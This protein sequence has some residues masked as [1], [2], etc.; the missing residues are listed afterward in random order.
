MPASPAERCED[1]EE[2]RLRRLATYHRYRRAN[3]DDR[4]EKGRLRMAALRARESSAQREERLNHHREAQKKYRE[5]FREQIAHR[6]RRAAV[7]KN[8]S[9][10]KAT[11]LRPKARQY[12]S[13][14]E[15]IT[16]DEEEEEEDWRGGVTVRVGI[17]VDI[18]PHT[19]R[20]AAETREEGRR[21][22]LVCGEHLTFPG[23]VPLF[24]LR[25]F[26]PQCIK[27]LPFGCTIRPPPRITRA[28]PSQ[29]P[30][31]PSPTTPRQ[32]L[33][34]AVAKVA[35]VPA[36]IVFHEKTA[37]W[38][39]ARRMLAM[40]RAHARRWW[41]RVAE[42]KE[43]GMLAFRTIAV[44]A[45]DDEKLLVAAHF[46]A[47]PPALKMMVDICVRGLP[48]RP[49]QGY[50]YHLVV[51][52][53]EVG[54]FDNWG[55]A[56]ASLTGY[57]GSVNKGF[58]SIAECVEA[59][60]AMCPLGVHPHPVDPAYAPADA[61]SPPTAPS[62]RSTPAPSSPG[63][64]S[65]PTLVFS[66]SPPTPTFI[67]S[68]SP[69][70]FPRSPPRAPNHVQ[71]VHN[72]GGQ[73]TP[74]VRK[75]EQ[76]DGTPPERHVEGTRTAA[77]TPCERAEDRS[78]DP[79][80]VNFAI[81]GRGIVSGSSPW[82]YTR[83]HQN[84]MTRGGQ[85]AR[86]RACEGLAPAKPGRT[87]WIHGTKVAF[88]EKFKNDYLKAAELGK[89]QAGK[90]YD[91]VAHA[92][93]KIYGYRLALTDDLPEGETVASDV[94]ED[95]DINDLPVEEALARSAHFDELRGC[96]IQVRREKGYGPVASGHSGARPKTSGR[97]P[98]TPVFRSG[99]ETTGVT[100][101]HSTEDE[102]TTRATRGTSEQKGSIPVF[103]DRGEPRSNYRAQKQLNN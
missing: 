83:K 99:R 60:Q 30:F 88:M 15:L 62:A 40:A 96:Y 27:G 89:V 53:H 69:P 45:R 65:T 11:K 97:G 52:G 33:G 47:R 16:D 8:E 86:A 7:K 21:R 36:E 2:R 9:V 67:F 49:R 78:T 64:A 61:P 55:A 1:E 3:L 81:R 91:D 51:Q 20:V 58:N 75:R 43:V 85:A 32:I 6:A 66:R 18:D 90:F 68:R 42:D 103:G 13:D 54:T 94:D 24:L 72:E 34:A 5:R 39:T 26:G 23:P 77:A 50:R 10:G 79:A 102:R 63:S 87:S 82:N 48:N 28:V 4:R 14:P 59:W 92:Y 80:P 25:S 56:K 93:L 37:G 101:R 57:H 17:G 41:V 12:W 44:S 73:S 95:E 38:R 29:S 31:L 100:L 70:P 71:R 74:R 84:L 76:G 46:G 35:P 22:R 98:K 19:L